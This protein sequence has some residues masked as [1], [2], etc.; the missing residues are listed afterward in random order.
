MDQAVPFQCSMRLP[1]ASDW[2]PTAQQSDA[3]TQETAISPDLTPDGDGLATGFHCEP[4][5]RSLKVLSPL[6][7]AEPT[8]RQVKPATQ[9]TSSSISKRFTAVG[10]TVQAVPFHRCAIAT[11]SPAW[12]LPP[13]DM[14]AAARTQEMPVSSV[15]RTLEVGVVTTD[16]ALPS[17]CPVI[18]PVAAPDAPCS[19][20][21]L[22]LTQARSARAAFSMVDGAVTMAHVLPFQCSNGT[23]PLWNS[24]Q[25]VM[26][27]QEIALGITKAAPC[28]SGSVTA[29]QPVPSQCWTKGRSLPDAS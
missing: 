26:V 6:S 22:S 20:Q 28:G 13:T 1:T 7:P 3:M 14:Q 10:V 29:D 25:L 17:Q 16:Q 8:A 4:F 21:S 12:P 2:L 5:Q 15:S 11:F 27:G 19:Q 24:Q 18:V 9:D 23:G